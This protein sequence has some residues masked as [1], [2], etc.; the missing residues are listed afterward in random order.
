MV[1]EQE[2]KEFIPGAG[3]ALKST[4]RLFGKK[5]AAEAGKEAG[6]LAIKKGVSAAAKEAGKDAAKTS[7]KDKAL[8]GGMNV[9]NFMSGGADV[10][11]DGSWESK[12]SNWGGLAGNI[13][14]DIAGGIAG[15]AGGLGVGA[16]PGA[17][18]GGAAGG[19]MGRKVGAILGSILDKFT[20]GNKVGAVKDL[21]SMITTTA[22]PGSMLALGAK[23]LLGNIGGSKEDM[24]GDLLSSVKNKI[25]D[26]YEDDIENVVD[27]I[28]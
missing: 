13:G 2:L 26:S 5:A 25:P 7:F 10:E 3:A 18:A 16:I 22:I 19:F 15:A 20:K 27:D 28:D 4:A 14:G 11:D 1:F 9:L 12:L 24:F 23:E 8:S 6:E 17:L 21:A